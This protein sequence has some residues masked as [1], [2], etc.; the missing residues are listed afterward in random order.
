MLTERALEFLCSLNYRDDAERRIC[1]VPLGG[2]YWSDE[3]PDFVA[4][5]K[6]PEDDRCLILRL[7]GI[8]FR[9][10][11]DEELSAD[12][13]AFWESARQQAPDYPV[14]Q[15]LAL[16]SD[17]RRA[18]QEAERQVFEAFQ[19]LKDQADHFE[20]TDGADDSTSFS[21]TFDL[22]R[23]YSKLKRW[24]QRFTRS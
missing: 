8:R 24:W 23:D 2:I 12:D 4:L 19:V 7:F 1:F 15:R 16:S 6:I 21:L 10:W 9:I 22:N 11:N 18:Q 3:V 14:F 13:R 20:L 5:Q 17:D